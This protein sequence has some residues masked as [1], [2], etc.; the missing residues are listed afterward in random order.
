MEDVTFDQGG[1]LMPGTV[2]VG[3]TSGGPLNIHRLDEDRPHLLD[4][5]C[6]CGPA[7]ETFG[8]EVGGMLPT[9]RRVASRGDEA[10]QAPIQRV[11][12]TSSED[13]MHVLDESC[14]CLPDALAE[15]QGDEFRM[16]E[17]IHRGQ[18]AVGDRVAV[19]DPAL[20]G[21]DAIFRAAGE[22][23]APNNEGVVESVRDDGTLL[24]VFDDHGSA[25][26]PRSQTRRIA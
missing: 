9:E 16:L 18:I 22:D 7:V 14:W 11:P 3:N 17:I 12:L 15:G 6:W 5:T 13:R 24:I 4:E 23:P 19:D 26:Y 20:A 8:E 10:A 21:I 25:P 1:V 2:I